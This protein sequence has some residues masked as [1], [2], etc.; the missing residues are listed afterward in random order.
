MP[1]V[2]TFQNGGDTISVTEGF[3]AEGDRIS[4]LA[5]SN[6]LRTVVKPAAEALLASCAK[7]DPARMKR[8]LASR[9][10][11]CARQI[12][13]GGADP[14]Y[15]AVAAVMPQ[16]I[17]YDF[18]GTERS[19]W[20]FLIHPNGGLTVT[21]RPTLTDWNS[22]D[23]WRAFS[24]EQEGLPYAAWPSGQGLLDGYL[25]VSCLYFRPAGGGPLWEQLCFAQTDAQ[26]RT[27]LHL[28]VKGDAEA[29]YFFVDSPDCDT[30]EEWRALPYQPAQRSA[31]GRE[32]Y[33][34]LFRLVQEIDAL[35]AEGLAFE[36]PEARA[37]NATRAALLKAFNTY[38]GPAP[39]YGATR[40]F[41]E[42]GMGAESFA[43]TTSTMVDACLAFGFFARA[44]E[45][46]RHYLLR[47]VNETGELQHR[48]GG[49]TVAEAG[50]LLQTIARYFYYTQD[51]Q[52]ADGYEI[53]RR[54]ASRL[55][56]QLEQAAGLVKGCPEDDCRH[57]EHAAWYSI[58]CWLY[59]GLQEAAE[60]FPTLCRQGLISEK[61][62][63]F[64]DAL[65]EKC[66]VLRRTINASLRE[67]LVPDGDLDF[68][69]PFP[70]YATPFP[71]LTAE[72]VHYPGCRHKL[73]FPAYVNYRCYLEMLSADALDP[74]LTDKLLR[75]REERGG[76]FLGV[77]RL[78][79]DLIDDWPLFNYLWALLREDHIPK[80][81]LAY[82]AH[83]AHHQARHT[84]FAPEHT[85]LGELLPHHCI[86]SQL[87][88]PLATRWMLVCELGD[89]LWL[90]RGTPR[91][92]LDDGQTVAVRNA[93][94]RWGRVSFALQSQLAQGRIAASIQFAA[95]PPPVLY[96]RFR[97]PEGK[98]IARVEAEFPEGLEL[99]RAK[100]AVRLEPR[101]ARELAFTVHCATD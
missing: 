4:F 3:A 45:Y 27:R 95:D 33:A 100:E 15:A 21:I 1:V 7:P 62:A 8:I 25:P 49:A 57:W 81:L 22:G 37:V 70:G 40:Y 44:K 35:L 63:G 34:E 76:E 83:L 58:N 39:R 59:R 64:A 47:Y 14:T 92:W 54:L 10:D 26:G 28:R 2:E 99:D 80:F 12:L 51:R 16:A 29:S 91:Q 38:V 46:L 17:S 79:G 18:L 89:G 96:C 85:R 93:P 86:P 30:P 67:G 53:A 42:L 71:S 13:A 77:T 41:Y 73:N 19:K 36:L 24:P 23:V 61:A 60:L 48:L 72:G 50:M 32:F 6:A 5:N 90:C 65:P 84:F 94:T 9:T 69:P 68:V 11:D 31:E 82:Y 43:P 56:Q 74:E 20:K 87:T 101:E 66:E 52:F 98:T 55:A 88:I 78:W 97:L 75:Y